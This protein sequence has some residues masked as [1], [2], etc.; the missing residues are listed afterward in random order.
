MSL[1]DCGGRLFDFV[2]MAF[3]VKQLSSELQF[4]NFKALK[5]LCVGEIA[6]PFIREL[7]PD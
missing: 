3:T 7:L 1:L 4:V 6:Y 2:Y 5:M